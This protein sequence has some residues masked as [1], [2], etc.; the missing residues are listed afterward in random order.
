M[1]LSCQPLTLAHKILIA[2]A[3]C[4]SWAKQL[5][6]D[7][8]SQGYSKFEQHVATCRWFISKGKILGFSLKIRASWQDSNNALVKK[9]WFHFTSSS[10]LVPWS[11]LPGCVDFRL[12]WIST[13]AQMH[14]VL[15]KKLIC[16]QKPEMTSNRSRCSF[17]FI[18]LTYACVYAKPSD[19]NPVV[20]ICSL[21]S[22]FKSKG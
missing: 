9:K 1:H 2:I 7:Q 15:S 6:Q 21:C 20:N 3:M 12:H 4:C 13:A 5:I 19:W 14:V 11:F 22:S 8:A 18:Y 10:S 16:L 17:C